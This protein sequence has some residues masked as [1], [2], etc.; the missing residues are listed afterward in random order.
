MGLSTG[1]DT[2][3]FMFDFPMSFNQL[4]FMDR[5][6]FKMNQTSIFFHGWFTHLFCSNPF[7]PPRTA[8][9]RVEQTLQASV[10]DL[11][12]AA[13]EEVLHRAFNQVPMGSPQWKQFGWKFLYYNGSLY[14]S[15]IYIYIMA[16]LKCIN[17]VY[18]GLLWWVYKCLF[19]GSLQ[20][21]IYWKVLY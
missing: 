13:E 3:V 21:Y 19:H 9:R 7:F 4:R 2:I 18:I 1:H 11:D 6:N 14:I 16:D 12:L 17:V 10:H 5:Y 20:V 8:S 15:T